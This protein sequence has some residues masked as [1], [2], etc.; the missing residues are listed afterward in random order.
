MEK[1]PIPL[2]FHKC[3]ALLV[4]FFL[5]TTS[6]ATSVS[7]AFIPSHSGVPVLDRE[8]RTSL[9][10]KIIRHRLHELG[11]SD[12]EINSRLQLLSQS[13]IHDLAAQEEALSS[14]GNTGLIISL[15][16]LLFWLIV[17]EVA[18][19]TDSNEW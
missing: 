6:T 7:A 2:F 14:G 13:D 19:R 16:I 8:T 9:Q 12:E 1:R 5:F 15:I 11:L 17:M 18:D 4:V 10:T 3:L